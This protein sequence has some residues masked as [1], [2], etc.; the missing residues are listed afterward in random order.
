MVFALRQQIANFKVDF[1]NINEQLIDLP[2]LEKVKIGDH[3]FE[4]ANHIQ[5]DSICCFS[6]IYLIFLLLLKCNLA[7][8]PAKVICIP[9]Y[10]Y[11][12]YLFFFLIDKKTFLLY[13]HLPLSLIPFPPLILPLFKVVLTIVVL[14]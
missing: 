12:V 7:N 9:V 3:C 5:F 4:K 2:L 11:H 8:L 13:N 1:L 14:R 10:S 6:L